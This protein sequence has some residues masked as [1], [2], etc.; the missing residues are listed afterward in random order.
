MIDKE[1]KQVCVYDTCS[2][3]VCVRGGLRDAKRGGERYQGLN[4]GAQCDQMDTSI[5]VHTQA[6]AHSER[7]RSTHVVTLT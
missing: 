3:S 4:D 2:Q 6:C 7:G 5:T 1:D